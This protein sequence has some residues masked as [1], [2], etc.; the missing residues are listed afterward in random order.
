MHPRQIAT[1]PA[2][3]LGNRLDPRLAQLD[4][5]KFGGDE[6]AVEQHQQQG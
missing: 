1:A 3:G 5:T 2:I 6:K 4:Q